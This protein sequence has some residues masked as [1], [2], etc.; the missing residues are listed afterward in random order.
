[1][2]EF[3]K[4]TVTRKDWTAVGIILGCTLLAAAL[5]VFLVHAEQKKKLDEV[6]ANLATKSDEL[7]KAEATQRD[8]AKLEKE[9][10]EVRAL[11]TQFERRL[12]DKRDMPQLLEQF[13]HM[14]Q[15]VGL[16]VTLT[17]QDPVVDENKETIPY[18]VA[19]RGNFHQIV[20]FINSLERHDRYLSVSDLD[21]SEQKDG[22]SEAKFTLS[23]FSFRQPGQTASVAAGAKPEAAAGGAAK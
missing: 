3:F 5:F 15:A 12:P 19:A 6:K 1:M 20:G 16:E 18:S 21:I 23:T 22:I 2:I 10:D 9:T 13:E 14:A 8:I 17:S 4:G 11:V 7:S